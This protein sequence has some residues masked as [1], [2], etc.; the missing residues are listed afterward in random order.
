MRARNLK[1]GLFDNELLAEG[2]PCAQV[3]FQGLWCMADREG[4][5]ENR[6]RRIR[7]KVFPYYDP[8]DYGGM[9]IQGLLIFLEERNFIKTYSADGGEYI[10][11]KN[12]SKHQSPH[13]SEKKSIFPPPPDLSKADSDST[14]VEAVDEPVPQPVDFSPTPNESET[15][16]RFYPNDLGK[17]WNEIADPVFPRVNLPFSDKRAAKFRPALKAIPDPDWWKALFIKAGSISFLRGDNDRGWR[18]DLEFVVRRREEILEGKYDRARRP[19]QSGDPDPRGQ[20]DCRICRGDGWE[21]VEE[22]GDKLAKPCRC[23]KIG[24]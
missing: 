10:Y 16:K 7:A 1:P 14:E 15:K 23:T 12:F 17:L 13:P 5:L 20:P 6:P 19:G 4:I 11:V 3:L 9:D 21:Y 8:K 18:A 22:N 2:G 24:A